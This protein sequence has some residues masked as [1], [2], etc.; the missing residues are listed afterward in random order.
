MNKHQYLILITDK[1]M[2]LKTLEGYYL[3]LSSKG[4][5]KLTK[6]SNKAANF[7]EENKYFTTNQSTVEVYK[8]GIYS[9]N[10]NNAVQIDD[11]KKVLYLNLCSDN[12][13]R[14]MKTDLKKILNTDKTKDILF[15]KH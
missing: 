13:Y 14:I 12:K 1:I 4:E 7:Y 2:K 9:S 10:K 8:E 3:K 11:G 5:I 6:S 15:I